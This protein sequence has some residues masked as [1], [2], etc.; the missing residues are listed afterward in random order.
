VSKHIPK[1]ADYTTDKLELAI[2]LFSK[3][4]PNAAIATKQVLFVTGK[5]ATSTVPATPADLMRD[6]WEVP[7][8]HR[9]QSPARKQNQG[10]QRSQLQ[11]TSRQVDS[12]EREEPNQPHF[13]KIARSGGTPRESQSPPP[14]RLAKP[15]SGQAPLA[16]HVRR[17]GTPAEAG[18][19][20]L[21]IFR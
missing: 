7:I 9:S 20:P 14:I 3:D 10:P 12:A 8:R 19:H 4:A 16:K 17:V 21:R 6:R 13:S 15:R 2:S 5:M 18:N 11:A 1:D